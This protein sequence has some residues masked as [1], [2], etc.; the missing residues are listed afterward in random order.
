MPR[1][2]LLFTRHPNAGCGPGC[3][4]GGQ[5][6]ASAVRGWYIHS[7]LRGLQR[8]NGAGG[9]AFF[10]QLQGAGRGSPQSNTL[11]VK[12]PPVIT[13]FI[14]SAIRIG[15][16]G[17]SFAISGAGFGSSLPGLNF[18]ASGITNVAVVT[19]SNTLIT[20]TFD[21]P[22][23]SRAGTY[24]LTLTP[25]GQTPPTATYQIRLAQRS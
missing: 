22:Q 20:G 16:T 25:G 10:G 3:P 18:G 19:Y 5:R 21:V 9:Q 8:S 23:A 24:T 4:D 17:V 14:P 15:A 2:I 6:D 7:S 11:Q 1:W 13:S 12:V